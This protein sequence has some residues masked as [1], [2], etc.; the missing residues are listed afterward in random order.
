MTQRDAV[1]RW[2]EQIAK[3][4]ARML[5]GPGPIDL[6]L[7]AD[8]V[9]AALAQHVGS[10]TL[11]LPQLDVPSAA[12]LLNEPERIFGYAQLLGLL[13]AVQHARGEAAALTTHARA[14]AF[15]REAI[16]RSLEAP[17]AWHDWLAEAEAWQPQSSDHRA[18]ENAG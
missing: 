18:A 13:G 11:L 3:V 12:T 2:I 16:G 15:A 6:D 9:E 8:Q 7:A 1:L 4:V 5:Y 17:R 10:L 14:I